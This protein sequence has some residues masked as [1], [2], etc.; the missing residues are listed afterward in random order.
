M[1][2]IKKISVPCVDIFMEK[3]RSAPEVGTLFLTQWVIG[4]EAFVSDITVVPTEE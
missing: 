4:T 1:N 2:V 3:E